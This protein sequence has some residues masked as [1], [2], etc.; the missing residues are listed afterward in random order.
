MKMK[1]EFRVLNLLLSVFMVF[2]LLQCQK[3]EMAP[4]PFGRV[5]GEDVFLY[6]LKNDR[7]VKVQ[8]TNYGGT[9][10]RWCVPDR[11]GNVA[12]IAL[13]FNSV[14]EYVEKSPYFGCIIGRFGNRI[15]NGKFILNGTEYVLATNNSPAGIPCHLHGGVKGF[16]K[17]IWDAKYIDG[18]EGAGLELH[19]ISQDGEEGYPGTLDVTVTYQLTNTNKLIIDY[20]AVADKPTP[21]NLTNHTYF[22]L[23]GEGQGNILDHE[24]TILADYM[25]PVTPGLIPT[26]EILPVSGTPFDFTSAQTIGSRIGEENQQLEYGPGYDHNWVLNSQNGTLALAATV[27]ES[28]SGRLME[29]YTTEPGLQFYSG[30]FL[31]GSLTGKS[32]QPYPLRSGFCLETQHYPDSPNQPQFPD[33]ILNPGDVYQTRTVYQFSVK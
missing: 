24:L 27:Y 15:A 26:G 14:E 29:V 33:T 17:R 32:G 16:D 23:K 22:N 3:P 19:Y 25:T 8:I 9:I 5:D 7:D 21:V 31:D 1:R 10:V 30:N 4:A 13:G 20:K 28:V 12:D 2:F 18:S 6:T 11:D